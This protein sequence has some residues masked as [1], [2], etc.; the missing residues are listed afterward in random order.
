[1]DTRTNKQASGRPAQ[2]GQ[3]TVA[4]G[5]AVVVGNYLASILV[6]DIRKGY[7]TGNQSINL[8]A[9]N[10]QACEFA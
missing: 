7:T 5:L 2:P 10:E 8:K 1:M 6:S 3:T 4:T 9:H